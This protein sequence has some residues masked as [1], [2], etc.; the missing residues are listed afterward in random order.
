META[1]ISY[2]TDIHFGIDAADRSQKL[3][4][5]HDGN[6]EPAAEH[7]RP[8]LED[9]GRPQDHHPSVR[10]GSLKLAD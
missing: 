8:Q 2:L 10:A 6:N 9:L 3:Q 1:R 4:S 7:F 5:A